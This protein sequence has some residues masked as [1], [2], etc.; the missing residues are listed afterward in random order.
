MDPQDNSDLRPEPKILFK[1]DTVDLVVWTFTIVALVW[2][3][4]AWAKRQKDKS[5]ASTVAGLA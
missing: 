2:M 4:G 1:V 5:K 3:G